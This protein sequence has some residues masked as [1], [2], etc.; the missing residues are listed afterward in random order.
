MP[1]M[2]DDLDLS[3]PLRALKR[4]TWLVLLLSLAAGAVTYLLSSRQTPVYQAK[5]LILSAGSQTSNPSVGN[6]VVS[7]RP[8]R[9]GPSRGRCK[10]R[11]CSAWCAA[12]WRRFPS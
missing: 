9:R 2:N 7:P 4:F 12:A 11:T 3:R 6:T 10:A 5:T 8:S 1:P